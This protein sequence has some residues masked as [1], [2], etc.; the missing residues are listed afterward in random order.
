MKL[1]GVKHFEW[2]VAYT[3]ETT[4][5]NREARENAPDQ[6]TRT[7][8]LERIFGDDIR[9]AWKEETAPRACQERAKTAPKPQP[10]TMNK[11][12]PV[13]WSNARYMATLLVVEMR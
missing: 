12:R 8:Q 5:G 2:H 10:T 11:Q 9:K 13:N 1:L 7:L 3:V 6:N 4:H